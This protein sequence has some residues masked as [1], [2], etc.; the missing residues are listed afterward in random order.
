M[1][2]LA[3]AVRAFY[4]EYEHDPRGYA[5]LLLELRAWVCGAWA[6]E[7]VVGSGGVATAKML[8]LPNLILYG[9]PVRIRIRNVE[10]VFVNVEYLCTLFRPVGY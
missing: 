2:T 7:V 5:Y 4:N 10:N 1:A 3:A 9:I 6:V 8:V